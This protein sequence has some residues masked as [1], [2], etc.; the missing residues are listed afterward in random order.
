MILFRS[1]YMSQIPLWTNPFCDSFYK[2]NLILSGWEVKNRFGEKVAQKL[3]YFKICNL[4]QSWACIIKHCLMLKL[5]QILTVRN[6][7]FPLHNRNQ[8][9]YVVYF[10]Q[11]LGATYCSIW[12]TTYSQRN[13]SNWDN[14]L[15]AI[16]I[17]I[18]IYRRFSR[19]MQ[20]G[21]LGLK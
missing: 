19:S 11:Q 4:F 15:S 17:Y 16:Y 10:N 20:L 3:E 2:I 9:W 21:G 1:I 5:R 7:N 12:W 6:K 14:F 13:Y 8:A 18:Y